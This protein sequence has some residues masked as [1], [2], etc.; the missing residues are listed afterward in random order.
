RNESVMPLVTNH[1]Y[2]NLAAVGLSYCNRG[3]LRR[4]CIGCAECDNGNKCQKDS[5]FHILCLKFIVQFL[6]VS[7]AKVVK[8]FVKQVK[9]GVCGSFFYVLLTTC[10]HK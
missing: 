1:G 6:T 4:H 3:S 5:F 9:R 10:R 2:R 8:S 7:S